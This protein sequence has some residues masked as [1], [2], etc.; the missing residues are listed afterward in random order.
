MW[1][2]RHTTTAATS[3]QCKRRVALRE[4][5]DLG[6]GDLG[7][8]SSQRRESR[9]YRRKR[10]AG[11]TYL[12]ALRCLT[13]RISDAVYRRLLADAATATIPM[14]TRDVD[15]SPGGQCGV[16]KNPARSTRT[17]YIDTLDRPLPDP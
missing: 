3:A 15:A 10:V 12:E 2:H 4:I 6:T 8:R 9:Y 13:R 17:R 16:L 7:M 14:A 1:R 5:G 11:K